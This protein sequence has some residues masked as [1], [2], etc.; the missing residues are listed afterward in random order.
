MYTVP[1]KVLLRMTT[2]RPHEELQALGDVV[3][4]DCS[5]GHA[6]FV[7]HQWLAEDHPDTDFKQM[8]VLQDA[9]KRLMSSSGSLPLDIVTESFVPTARP[10]RMHE[11]QSQSLFLWYDYFS[12]P[13]LEPNKADVTNEKDGSCLARAIKSIP[14]YITHARFF[15]A[16]CPVLDCA[17][18][19][20]VLSSGSWG[21]PRGGGRCCSLVRWRGN[22]PGINSSPPGALVAVPH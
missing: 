13:Q 12:C 7:S 5:M 14:A 18:Q 15:I 6:A 11:I 19:K 2:I 9:L 3:V 20:T 10:L 16:L 8:Q 4:F 1:L 21:P 22:Q 17:E